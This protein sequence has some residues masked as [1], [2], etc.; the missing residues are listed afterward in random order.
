M[1]L[2]YIIYVHIIINYIYAR[3]DM[4]RGRG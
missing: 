4:R 3:W 2:Y 1:Y